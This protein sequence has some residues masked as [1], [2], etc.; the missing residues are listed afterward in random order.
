MSER[1][2]AVPAIAA[3]TFEELELR[4]EGHEELQGLIREV[5]TVHSDSSE[6][7]QALGED[8][9]G[10]RANY[11]YV[12][13]FVHSA[14]PLV[15]EAGQLFKMPAD[16]KAQ[17]MARKIQAN[18]LWS[19]LL[20][21]KEV[22]DYSEYVPFYI[23]GHKKNP[24]NK[25]ANLLLLPATQ[26]LTI[27]NNGGFKY[28]RLELLLA[29]VDKA[30]LD[31][32]LMYSE[33]LEGTSFQEPKKHINDIGNL[34]IG[35]ETE[36]SV[37]LRGHRLHFVYPPKIDP[38]CIKKN[39]KVSGKPY[40]RSYSTLDTNEAEA[41]GVYERM[42]QL[43]ID[44]GESATLEKNSHEALIQAGDEAVGQSMSYEQLQ[45]RYTELRTV[46]RD[47]LR[48]SGLQTAEQVDSYLDSRFPK[49]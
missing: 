14:L 41:L 28:S 20:I 9:R 23:I 39:P 32:W 29:D 18:V 26:E 1:Q 45:Q 5:L 38:D 34:T 19:R 33:K 31:H 8:G 46:M 44:F 36:G 15:S 25:T 43:A 13:D 4:R 40:R 30:D 42:A 17:F 48:A 7:I 47:M 35:P 49:K 2:A 22:A 16:E 10:A 12:R 27:V 24:E 3:A 37:S 6:V 11:T 21:S